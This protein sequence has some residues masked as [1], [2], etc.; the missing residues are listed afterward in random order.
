MKTIRPA[1]LAAALAAGALLAAAV[2]CANAR[3]DLAPEGDPNR[4]LTGTVLFRAE[5]PLPP[6]AEVL[7]RVVDPASVEQARA[8][9]NRDLP[10]ATRAQAPLPPTVI[11]EQTFQAGG[12]NNGVPFQIGFRAS[13]DLLRHGLNL[14]ARISAGGRVLFRTVNARVVTLANVALNHELWVATTGR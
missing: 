4:V 11:A 8:A 1:F 2:G 12:A 14:E 5:Q 7:V 10:V 9:A 3:L 13:D 6:D